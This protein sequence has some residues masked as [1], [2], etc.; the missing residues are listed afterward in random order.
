MDTHAISDLQCPFF[1]DLNKHLGDGADFADRL[2]NA[3][4]DLWRL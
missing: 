1:A 3:P 2:F 4:G